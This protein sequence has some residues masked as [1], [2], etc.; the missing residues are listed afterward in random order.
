MTS[1]SLRQNLVV[2]KACQGVTLTHGNVG[3]LVSGAMRV[4]AVQVRPVAVDSPQDQ[5]STDVALVPTNTNL[6]WTD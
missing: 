3:Q 1:P 5:S 2:A 4:D 6:V